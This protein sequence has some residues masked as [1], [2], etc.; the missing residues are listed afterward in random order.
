MEKAAEEIALEISGAVSLRTTVLDYDEI[1]L[2]PEEKSISLI[3]HKI[4]CRYALRFGEA[5]NDD[6][7]QVTR[8]DQVRSAFNSPFR[9]FILA[10]TS[11][12]Q[13]ELDFH[14][15]CHHIHHWN[16]PSN[17]VDLEQREGRIHRYKGHVIRKN[18]A[19]GNG[20]GRLTEGAGEFGDPWSYMFERAVL[21]RGDQGNDLI[22]FWICE[23]GDN[24]VVRHFPALPL[25]RECNHLEDLKRT[26]VAYR[27]VFGQPRQEDLVNYL[28]ARAKDGERLK[29]ILRYRIDLRPPRVG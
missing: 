13:E 2:K 16:L 9:P 28:C 3:K 18:L 22:P 14:Q 26:L 1:K 24:K 17:P 11:I 29:E 15:Y 6:D 21:K 12:V 20:L 8:E 10:T 7:D 23:D 19:Q 25:N 5:K 4:R 27:M